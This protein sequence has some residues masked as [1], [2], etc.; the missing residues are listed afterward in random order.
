MAANQAVGRFA[1]DRDVCTPA[2]NLVSFLEGL[3]PPDAADNCQTVEVRR[4]EDSPVDVRLFFRDRRWLAGHPGR[5]FIDMLAA[6][7]IVADVKVKGGAISLRLADNYIDEV[8]AALEE[9]IPAGLDAGMLLDGRAFMVGFAGPNTSKALHVG[10]LRNICIGNALAAVLR[11]AGADVVRHSLV[12][13]IGRNI[14]EA[15]AGY[16]QFHDGENPALRGVK[17]DRFIGECYSRYISENTAR[18]SAAGNGGDP[19]ARELESTGDLADEFMRG[20]LAGDPDTRVLWSTIRSWVMD[21]HAHTLD[22]FGVHIDRHDFESD[23]MD[24][25]PALMEDGL[26]RGIVERDVDGTILYRSGREE[27]EA[28]ILVRP[29]GF[30]TEH[31]RLLGVYTRLMEERAAN[32]TYIDLSGTEWQPASVLHTE[33]MNRLHPDGDNTGHV[34]LFH[35][36]VTLKNSKMSSSGGDA[37]LIDDLLDQLSALPAVREVAALSHGA[38]EPGAVADIAVKCFFLCRPNLKGM[39]FSWEL[40]TEAENPGWTI[41]RA[42]CLAASPADDDGEAFNPELYRLAAIRSQ[43]FHRNVRAAADEYSL[44]GLT[45]YLLHFCEDYLK[46]PGHPRQKRLARNVIGRCLASLGMIGS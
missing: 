31:A 15:M 13:D 22:R 25:V 5:A 12:G 38:V 26:R 34:L 21:G 32:C 35:G 2:T 23:A 20:W 30:P 11:V 1:G 44:A 6:L 46:A 19:I 36:M 37:L 18:P 17:S 29:D 8:G 16:T 28:M 43:E 3:I 24:D 4:R 7:D 14:C 41:A 9:G 45:S 27:F 10:H 42:W 33:L 39:E 40:L